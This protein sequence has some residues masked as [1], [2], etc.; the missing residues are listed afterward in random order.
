M[1][2]LLSLTFILIVYS[3]S[4]LLAASQHASQYVPLKDLYA[5]K[6][7]VGNIL[8]GGLEGNSLFRQDQEELALLIGEFNCLTAENSMKMQYVQPK[9]GVFNFKPSDAL[10]H[11]ANKAEMEVVGHAL[12]WHHQVPQW[13]FKDKQG[14]TVSREVLIQRMKDHIYKVVTRYK[15]KIKYWDVVNEAVDLKYEDGKQV[16]FLRESPWYKIIGEDYI[17]LAYRFAHEA[18]PD[19][20][21]LYNDYSMTDLVK[22]QF[23]ADMVKDLKDKGIPIHGVG[24]QGHWHLEWPTNS[25]LRKALDILSEVGVKVSISELDVRVL[26]HPKDT[27]MGAD[28]RLNVQRLKEL[29][30]YT[31]GI[32]DKILKKQAKKY[33]SLF[34]VFLEYSDLIERVSFWGV[35]DHHSWLRDW[36]VKGRTVYPALFDRDYSPKPAYF[37]IRKLVE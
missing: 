30:P 17:E 4:L 10:L 5:D 9:E 36:P 28:I 37:A 1:I 33:A 24:M 19:A 6:F 3:Q 26:P 14:N 11:I 8:A 7:L 20:L 2:R 35:V 12:V 27:E 29:D 15:G 13:I 21:L 31:D 22:T 25:D 34:K 18:D 23:V 16:A 32:P